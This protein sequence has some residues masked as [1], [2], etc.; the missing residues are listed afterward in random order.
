MGKWFEN[1]RGVKQGNL[2]S[3][4]IFVLVVD[5]LDS[6]LNVASQDNLFAGIGRSEVCALL[7]DNGLP[8]SI[9][10]SVAIYANSTI[11]ICF[12]CFCSNSTDVPARNHP[13]Y[14]IKASNGLDTISCNIFNGFITYED[15]AMANKIPNPNK[16]EVGQKL[17][18][19]LP[20]SCDLMDGATM[21][22]YTHMVVTESS[23]EGIMAE[24]RMDE[25]KGD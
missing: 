24:F 20:Y 13:L 6:A 16:I 3:P 19:P 4:L 9:H 22:H 15:I 18:I 11:Y 14:K 2:I 8:L 1:R 12:S 7:D 5:L 23:I 17:W 25:D 10:S 21:V